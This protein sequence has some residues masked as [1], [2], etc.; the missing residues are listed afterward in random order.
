MLCENCKEDQCTRDS[1]D[2]GVGI[3]YGP[4]GCPSCG[5]S[6]WD[7]YD[8][9]KGQNPMDEKGGVID[10]YGSYHPP[11]SWRALAFKKADQ[12]MKEIDYGKSE[13]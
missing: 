7:E 5:W 10:Q 1:V 8:L 12:L 2:N 6:E 4:Y 11:G 3:V 9:S 13:T